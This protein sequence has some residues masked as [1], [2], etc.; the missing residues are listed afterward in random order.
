VV[1]EII[2]KWGNCQTITGPFI[3]FPFKTL[4]KGNDGKKQFNLN[5]LHILPETL[6]ITGEI[7]SEV[8]YRSL[9]EAVVYNT[10]LKF[11]GNFKLPSSSQLNSDSNNIL[12]D[13]P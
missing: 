4:F 2:Q 9:F 8:R 5:Y 7:E 11:K 13:T 3:T 1:E 6:D 10:K 12:W